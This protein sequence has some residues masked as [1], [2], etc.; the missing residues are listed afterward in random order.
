MSS[1]YQLKVDTCTILKA[2]K[3]N[4]MSKDI[5]IIFDRT[6]M[7]MIL[8]DPQNGML[9]EFVYNKDTLLVLQNLY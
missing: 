9:I 2:G 6:K 7:T 3:D 8:K 4:V 1:I 5:S